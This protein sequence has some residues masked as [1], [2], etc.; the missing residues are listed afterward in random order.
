[1]RSGR[2][3]IPIPSHLVEKRKERVHTSDLIFATRAGKLNGHFL[4]LLKEV[5]KRAGVN[6]DECGLCEFQKTYATLQHENGVSPR[7]IQKRLGHSSLETTLPYL[8]A[9]S[10]RSKETW[11]V[12]NETF[13]AFA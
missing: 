9:A 11:Q 3:E 13:A 7:T 6:P 10:V 5:A 12:V 1:M 4:R 8:E 2:R